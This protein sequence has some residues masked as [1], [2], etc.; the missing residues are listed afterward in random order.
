MKI[1][2]YARVSTRDQNP[3]LQLDALKAAGCQKIYSD[4]ATGADQDRA[5]LVE[6]L[7]A[8]GQGD[9]LVIWKLD[10]VGRSL[11]DLVRL[12]D[13]LRSRGAALRSIS[14]ALD[15]STSAGR[16]MYGLIAT[17]AAFER[18][19][20]RE[21]TSAGLAAAKRRGVRLG[22]R[23]KLGRDQIAHA[24][25]MIA[26]DEWTAADAA[27][28]FRVGYNTMKRAI[29]REGPSPAGPKPVSGVRGRSRRA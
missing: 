25:Q 16:M 8:L 20:L 6:A 11:S 26:Q 13:D 9:V 19:I 4:T 22:R 28:H 2:G 7:A 3:A 29:L 1:I 15:L 5:G 24:V 17:F 27:R 23:R 21:R 14:E 12:M 10:R 18:D